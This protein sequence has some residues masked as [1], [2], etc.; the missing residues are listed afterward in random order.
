MAPPILELITLTS[1]RCDV[2]FWHF[3]DMS[4]WCPHVCLVGK[5]GSGQ[6]TAK[7]TLMTLAGHRPKGSAPFWSIAHLC[8]D[9]ETRAKHVACWALNRHNRPA[10]DVD[11]SG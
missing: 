8:T 9:P 2:A 10:D 7:M 11:S 1:G 5:I 6:S 4:L 3:S